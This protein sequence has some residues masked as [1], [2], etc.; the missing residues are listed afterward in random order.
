MFY[1]SSLGLPQALGSPQGSPPGGSP[2]SLQ[3]PWTPGYFLRVPGSPRIEL[4]GSAVPLS[5]VQITAPPFPPRVPAAGS[6]APGSPAPGSPKAQA[7]V[8]Y[9]PHAMPLGYL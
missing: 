3:V 9:F 4:A 1:P 6:P 8:P 2:G 7:P 5:L